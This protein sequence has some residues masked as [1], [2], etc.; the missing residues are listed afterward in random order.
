VFKDTELHCVSKIDILR[1]SKQRFGCKT[2]RDVRF[3]ILLG[4]RHNVSPRCEEAIAHDFMLAIGNRSAQACRPMKSLSMMLKFVVTGIGVAL[5]VVV[6][7]A[8]AK[9]KSGVEMGENYAIIY[10]QAQ[11]SGN[12]C[13]E[14]NRVL[15]KYDKSL[16]K[17]QTYKEGKLV[18]TQG[19]LE[20]S[21]M[22]RG[23]VSEVTR[24]AQEMKFTGC[25]IEAGRSNLPTRAMTKKARG[26]E[27]PSPSPSPS[28]SPGGS[29][30]LQTLIP[31][32]AEMAKK[33]QPVVDKYNKR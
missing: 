22:R 1:K 16:Y 5:F 14:L 12:N 8:Y 27:E 24:T 23:L 19:K 7:T 33:V 11:W 2:I 28:A 30:T 21:V 13:D 3:H 17:I 32:I 31:K 18:K 10:P 25:A 20:E 9:S 15:S 26:E 4:G 29:T 6:C